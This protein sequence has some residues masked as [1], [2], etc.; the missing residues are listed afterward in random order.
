MAAI[1][2][3]EQGH[4]VTL[5]ESSRFSNETGAAI[6]MAP[7]ANGL[8]KRYGVDIEK[9]GANECSRIAQY[10]AESGKALFQVDLTMPNKQWQHKWLL[11]HRA[12][13]H[14]AL[15]ERA[16]G[17]EGKGKPATLRLASKVA[18]VDPEKA[19]VTLESGEK[20]SGDVLLGADGVHVSL[21]IKKNLEC[22]AD[23]FAV[24][25]S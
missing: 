14:N 23:I 16:I 4:D 24:A 22:Q 13:L 6:H 1:A 18:S 19:E 20:V 25:L 2:L 15:R 9:V 3:R 10:H 7:N 11:V 17:Q 21:T 5:L 8:L 12:H